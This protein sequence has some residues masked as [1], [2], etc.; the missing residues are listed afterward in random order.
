MLTVTATQPD[1]L[2][3]CNGKNRRGLGG[4]AASTVLSCPLQTDETVGDV[5]INDALTERQK[6]VPELLKS[7]SST[8]TDK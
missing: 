4:T 1:R 6:E 3:R 2:R 8:L 5:K 7:F